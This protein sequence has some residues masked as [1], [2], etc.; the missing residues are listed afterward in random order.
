LWIQNRLRCEKSAVFSVTAGRL[1][2]QFRG[3]RHNLEE[4]VQA[5]TRD[6]VLAVL[7]AVLAKSSARRQ[8]AAA[9]LLE[10]HSMASRSPTV[11][12]N[13]VHA[14]GSVAAARELID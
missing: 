10:P 6:E 7:R 14:F 3:L 2:V 1:H 13:A 9:H 5:L 11:F 4:I 12:W 8:A